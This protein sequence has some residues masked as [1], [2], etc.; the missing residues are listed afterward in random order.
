MLLLSTSIPINDQLKLHHLL[1]I[2]DYY[3]WCNHLSFAHAG[4]PLH[5]HTKNASEERCGELCKYS[6]MMIVDATPLSASYMYKRGV[7]CLPDVYHNIYM[8]QAF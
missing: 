3:S 5:V 6:H 1:V 2:R 4:S 7:W 8:Y